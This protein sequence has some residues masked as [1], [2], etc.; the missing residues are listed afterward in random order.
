MAMKELGDK[1]SVNEFLSYLCPGVCLLLSLVL[2]VRPDLE[3]AFGKDLG[4]KEGIIIPFLLI[5]GY[6]IGLIVAAWSGQ[7]AFFYLAWR[8]PKPQGWRRLRL[9]LVGLLHWMP[10]QPGKKAFRDSLVEVHLR[11]AEGVRQHAGVINLGGAENPWETVAIYRALVAGQ[12]G[13]AGESIVAAAEAI[14]TRMAFTLNMALVAALI[15][16]EALVRLFFPFGHFRKLS[17]VS[18]LVLTI[19]FV[20]G[21]IVSLGLRFAAARW[22]TREVILTGSLAP[23]VEGGL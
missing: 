22:R 10:N 3:G 23:L 18:P 13:T 4:G 5:V 7:G 12:T 17:T 20:I 6:A 21:A 9:L 2:W 15:A 8:R 19:V 11:I 1:F 14:H 16:L